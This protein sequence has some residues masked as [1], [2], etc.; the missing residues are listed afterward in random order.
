M[1]K[2]S[3]GI[4]MLFRLDKC[5]KATFIKGKIDKAE[6]VTL[7]VSTTSKELEQERTINT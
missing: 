4:G 1:K 3:D 2:F 5:A 6:N 7:D